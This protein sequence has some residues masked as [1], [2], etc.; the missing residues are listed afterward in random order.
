M[1][2]WGTGIFQDDFTCDVRDE[3]NDLAALK[4]E[5]SEIHTELQE[6][7]KPDGDEESIFW[8]ALALAQ[9]KLGRLDEK[10]KEKA[11]KFIDSGKALEIWKALADGDKASIRGRDKALSKAKETILSPQAARKN[12]KPSA[13][14]KENIDQ[15]FEAYTWQQDH[16][17]T[18]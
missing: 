3:Y 18:Y 8:I 15:K 5:D 14:L 10:T 7:F 12:P 16:L 2:A 17:Y 1:G 13:Y 9:H 11:L 4:F 6:S